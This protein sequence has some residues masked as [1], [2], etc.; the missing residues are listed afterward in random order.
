MEIGKSIDKAEVKKA[1]ENVDFDDTLG[2][3][4]TSVRRIVPGY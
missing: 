1:M 3:F 4:F 2:V